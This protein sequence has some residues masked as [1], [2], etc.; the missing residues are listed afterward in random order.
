MIVGIE[1]SDQTYFFL[2]FITTFSNDCSFLMKT[3]NFSVPVSINNKESVEI[4]K[5]VAMANE[6]EIE[7]CERR[8][9]ETCG[10]EEMKK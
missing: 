7:D 1:T 5:V 8:L 9:R 3:K 10:E 4:S 2:L 6:E